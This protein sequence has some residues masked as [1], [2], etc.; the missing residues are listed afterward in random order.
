[1]T[2]LGACDPEDGGPAVAEANPGVDPRDKEALA[3]VAGEAPQGW[4]EAD[5]EL[6]LDL[7]GEGGLLLGNLRVGVREGD[8][9]LGQEFDEGG[10]VFLRTPARPHGREAMAKG[11]NGADGRRSLRC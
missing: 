3:A 1:V 11:L 7:P 8:G 6:E 4:V 10:G 9:G 5:V 2:A